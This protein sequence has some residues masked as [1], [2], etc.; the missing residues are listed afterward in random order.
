ML[1]FMLLQLYYGQALQQD[2][3]YILGVKHEYL[4]SFKGFFFGW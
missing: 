4:R 1:L 2:Y 3:V